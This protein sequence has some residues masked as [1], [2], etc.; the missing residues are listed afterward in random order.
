MYIL[1]TKEKR[2]IPNN[3]SNV[4]V[5]CITRIRNN[6]TRKNTTKTV[7]KIILSFFITNKLNNYQN[8]VRVFKGIDINEKGC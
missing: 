6:A 1:P 5:C 3:T 4:G 2:E 8:F 7:S